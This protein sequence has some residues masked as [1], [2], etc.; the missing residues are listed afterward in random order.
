MISWKTYL[1][2][3]NF[4]EDQITN[5]VF[6]V[7]S[8]CIYC[9]MCGLYCGGKANFCQRC[10]AQVSQNYDQNGNSIAVYNDQHQLETRSMSYSNVYEKADLY[11]SEEQISA[12][13]TGW[14]CEYCTYFNPNCKSNICE[15][16]S[17][18]TDSLQKWNKNDES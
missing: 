8:E 4:W 15:M 13:A 1:V 17:K 16:C 12:E 14:G 11:V 10:G 9:P 7:I 18:T 3:V 6:F 5:K 2:S